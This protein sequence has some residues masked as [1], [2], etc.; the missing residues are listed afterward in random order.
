[1][2]AG[3]VSDPVGR[4][5][6]IQ[7][8]EIGTRLLQALASSGRSLLLRDLSRSAGMPAAKARRYLVS[9]I[10]M[11]L[12]E[13][14]ANTGR[15]DL[16]GFALELGLASLA[17]LDPVRLAG[18]V[19]DDLCERTGET[20]A[21]AMWGNRGATCVRW[22]EAGGP[23]TVTLR[24]GVVLPLLSSATGLAFAA[25]FRSPYLRRMLD[26]E[27]EAAA[28]AR[29]ATPTALRAALAVQL[30]EVR[31]HG[32]ARAAG[33]VTPGVN[34]FSAPVF[35]DAGRMVAA[36]TLLGIIGS[37]DL[38]W[39]SPTARLTKEAAAT[40]SRRLGYGGGEAAEG[41]APAAHGDAAP[42][43]GATRT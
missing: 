34:G 13:Q 43:G 24:T 42:G 23:V 39:D 5:Q 8:V 35:N 25:F 20:V 19:L 9:F 30:D 38:D 21:L 4:R 1:M 2:P 18:P 32:I 3:D 14:D 29:Q 26:A 27:I 7:S 17:R 41:E 11:G 12:V 37:F 16:G 28:A 22:L 6:G 36:L 31:R 10:R 15:Y 40:L 33:S